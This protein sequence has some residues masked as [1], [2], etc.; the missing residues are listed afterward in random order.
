MFDDH[1]TMLLAT[2][3]FT[4]YSLDRRVVVGD[5]EERMIHVDAK[6]EPD[7]LEMME[8]ADDLLEAQDADE[9]EE[10]WKKFGERWITHKAVI[11]GTG[12]VEVR[13]ARKH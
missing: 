4:I 10:C 8:Y 1:N 2:F 6:G 9:V 5:V 7:Q 13:V 12:R 3:V 11:L